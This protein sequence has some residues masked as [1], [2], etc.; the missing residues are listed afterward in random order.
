M[1]ISDSGQSSPSDFPIWGAI[2]FL[3]AEP[4]LARFARF[5]I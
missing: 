2:R 1:S 5:H 4:G 3:A